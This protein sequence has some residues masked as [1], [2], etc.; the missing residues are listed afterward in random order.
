MWELNGEAQ[1]P[2]TGWRAARGS[3]Q[4]G[5][6]EEVLMGGGRD[7]CLERQAGLCVL[8]RDHGSCRIYDLHEVASRTHRE[9]NLLLQ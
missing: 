6:Q 8:G 9:T 2:E 4:A 5:H 7:Y 1:F 3:V